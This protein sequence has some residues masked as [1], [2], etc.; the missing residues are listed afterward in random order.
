MLSALQAVI[1]RI[2]LQRYLIGVWSCGLLISSPP[3]VSL[4]NLCNGKWQNAIFW[5]EPWQD[6]IFGSGT[7]LLALLMTSFLLLKVA[8]CLEEW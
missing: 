5:N 6:A 8:T 3:Q 4:R 2:A 7:T 1:E